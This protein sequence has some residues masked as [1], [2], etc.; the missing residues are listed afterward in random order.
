ML[1]LKEIKKG[2]SISFLFMLPIDYDLDRLKSFKVKFGKLSLIGGLTDNYI[3]AQVTSAQTWRMVGKQELTFTIDD[4]NIGIRKL[5]TGYVSVIA[6]NETF[7]DLSVSEMIDIN[8][9][10]TI[11]E[12]E[13]EVSDVL[14]DYMK[15][16]DGQTG[17]SDY[18]DLTN[19]PS[20][21]SVELSGN[22]TSADLG[23]ADA[24]HDHFEQTLTPDVVEYQLTPTTPTVQG[25][26]FWDD[27]YKV[28]STVL[29]DGVVLQNGLEM[30]VRVLNKTGVQINDGEVVY[31][32]DAQG[33]KPTVKL[34]IAMTSIQSE[35]IGVATQ[36]IGI[37][38]EGFV[39]VFGT[40][41]G[42]NTSGYI[43]G[44]NMYLS[45]TNAG[46]LTDIVP[47]YPNHKVEVAKALNSTSNGAIFVHPNHILE[48]GELHGVDLT[49]TK[50][51]PIFADSLLLQDS[52]GSIW[53]KITWLNIQGTL[54]AYFDTI[55]STAANLLLKR[56]KTEIGD[57]H[58]FINPPNASN[59]TISNVDNSIT[60]NLLANAGNYKI[61]GTDYVNSGL[62]LTFTA[63]LGQN[64]INVN[65]N[66]LLI[67]AFDIL[68]LTKTLVCTIN[69]DGTNARLSDELHLS[70]RNLIEHKKQHDTDG[71]RWV[72]GFITSFGSSANNTFSSASGVIRDEERY[73]NIA[74]K[75]QGVIAYRNATLNAMIFDTATTRF[76]KLV[77]TT[78]GAPYYDL[79]GVLTA[80]ATNRYGIMWMYG[81][82]AKLPTNSEI[83]FIM[84][85]DAYTSVANTQAAP[86]PT[87]VGM[88]IA[89]WKLLYRVIIRNVGGSLLFVRADDLRVQTTGL[90]ISGSGLTSLPAS[91]VTENNYGN[92]QIAIDRLKTLQVPNETLIAANW[93]LVSG[94]YEY[95]LANA[96][97]TATSFVDVIINED[98]E[99]NIAI[100]K[101]SEFKQTNVSSNGSVKIFAKNL[102]SGNIVVTLNIY[103]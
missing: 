87:L 97:I 101:A 98:T 88:T 89:E 3:T 64:F 9:I 92:V 34:A 13:I 59:F 5:L 61:N 77:G 19:K 15:G 93:A 36:N 95:D 12:T 42:F 90:A 81:T 26:Q 37:N 67:E 71:A 85:Q 2:D 27:A 44:A 65:S 51:T 76:S 73:H 53:K 49:Q 83:V 31:I 56:D 52:V 29:G 84:G 16:K 102:P 47:A 43:D 99:E 6:T 21:N 7:N 23:L 86:Q 75:T 32:N 40:V 103:E 4:A 74:A 38:A 10:L 25:S 58:G 69:W 94:Y 33:N 14:Y 24:D 66:G 41:N 96:N 50:T 55:Y 91:S 20:I 39:T 45:S 80:L 70:N 18:S 28:L 1:E 68:D 17:T 57:T 48:L 8:V 30:Y 79:N 62:S 72:S 82:N 78:S 54:K 35:V 63:N 60:L 22:K 11:N 100:A 46:K